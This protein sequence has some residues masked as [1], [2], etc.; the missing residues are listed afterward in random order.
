MELNEVG[1]KFVRKCI[2]AVETKGEELTW[3]GRASH[4]LELRCSSCSTVLVTN[5]GLQL[6]AEECVFFSYMHVLWEQKSHVVRNVVPSQLG[7]YFH[8]YA[9]FAHGFLSFG[10][11]HTHCW[12]AGEQLR[13]QGRGWLQ[14]PSASVCEA[15]EAGGGVAA[16]PLGCPYCP[17]CTSEH[18]VNITSVRR[19]P[20]F[21]SAKASGGTKT[22]LAEPGETVALPVPALASVFR[23]SFNVFV[24]CE[25][26]SKSVIK[27]HPQ[28][29]GVW[30]GVSCALAVL[31]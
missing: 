22:L 6:R 8:L 13:Q 1:F 14:A 21:T 10:L 24:F 7:L 17:A 9:D 16:H 2:N 31:T 15:A 3:P 4:G 19:G 11:E 26:L 25:G 28:K 5:T 30:P 23:F 27:Q 12:A 20:G 18:P 29:W